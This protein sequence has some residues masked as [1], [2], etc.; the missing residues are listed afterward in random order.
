M[1]HDWIRAGLLI[2][3]MSCLDEG[4]ACLLPSKAT[5]NAFGTSNNLV[6]WHAQHCV[7]L[8]LMLCG[9]L[10][11]HRP[12]ISHACNAWCEL[13]PYPTLVSA[14]SNN[15][16]EGGTAFCTGDLRRGKTL[17]LVVLLR[18]DDGA[19]RFQ[20][21]MLLHEAVASLGTLV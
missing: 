15:D 6:H 16:R 21:K 18:N 20:I 17:E 19:V 5:T 13:H 10:Q 8:Q 11:P 12:D 1:C 9:A 7:H 2:D 14:G 3:R 4:G